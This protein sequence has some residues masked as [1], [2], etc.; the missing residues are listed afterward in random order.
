MAGQQKL[1]TKSVDWLSSSVRLGRSRPGAVGL[2]HLVCVKTTA[3]SDTGLGAFVTLSH[4]AL[5]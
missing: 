1:S 5:S 4:M 2:A 3:H